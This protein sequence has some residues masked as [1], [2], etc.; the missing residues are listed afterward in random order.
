MSAIH[1]IKRKVDVA[2]FILWAIPYDSVQRLKSRGEPAKWVGFRDGLINRWLSLN[3]VTGLILGAVSTVVCSNIHLTALAFALGIVS[4][5]TS[6]ISIGFGTGLI[7]V[8]GD[9]IADRYTVLFP[10]ALAIPQLWAAGSFGVFFAEILV[11]TWSQRQGG[12]IVKAGVIAAIVLTV[13][14][15]GGFLVLHVTQQQEEEEGPEPEEDAK[16]SG[17]I[18]TMPSPEVYPMRMGSND[19]E[20]MFTSEPQAESPVK[21]G[22]GSGDSSTMG[23]GF[24]FIGG[25]GSSKN[26]SY[27]PRQSVPRAMLLERNK[28][29]MTENS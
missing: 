5:L 2:A 7:Y 4:L 13:V 22:S 26:P 6:L 9:I 18:L 21:V 12:W 17:Q 8:L 11:I 15:L 1:N 28:R 24:G 27:G 19:Q 16:G 3:V 20:N 29:S 25:F 10:Y 23:Q 14:H